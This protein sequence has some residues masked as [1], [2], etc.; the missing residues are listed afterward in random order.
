MPHLSR[1][2]QALGTLGRAE[3]L[4]NT[5]L[6]CVMLAFVHHALRLKKAMHGEAPITP[7]HDDIYRR[8]A[9]ISNDNK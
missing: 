8:K 5:Q 4:V 3:P 6:L 7:A 2:G 1:Y 9:A